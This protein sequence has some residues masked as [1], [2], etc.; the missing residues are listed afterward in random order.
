MVEKNIVAAQAYYQ[1]INNKDVAAAEKYLHADV[2]VTSPLD[3]LVGKE[4]VLKAL[5]FFIP[6]VK[7]L[8]VRTACGGDNQVMLAVDVEYHEPIGMLKTA[9]L[10]TFQDGLIVRNE[11]FFDARVFEKLKK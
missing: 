9:A 6:Y 1:A 10:M 7:N 8:T 11:I 3:N 5:N 2:V 4:A